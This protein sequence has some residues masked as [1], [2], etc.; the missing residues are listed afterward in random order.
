MK[1]KVTVKAV[2]RIDT[3]EMEQTH[4]DYKST[5]DDYKNMCFNFVKLVMANRRAHFRELKERLGFSGISI[6]RLGQVGFNINI[7]LLCSSLGAFEILYQNYTTGR[8]KKIV[9]SALV[10][11]DHLVKLKAQQLDLSVEMDEG[12]INKY[13]DILIVRGPEEE[14]VLHP[15]DAIDYFQCDDDEENT[16]NN[17]INKGDFLILLIS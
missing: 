8:L 13:R 10:T 12:L 2:Q 16:L 15:V 14:A 11:K 1:V 7:F 9:H 5:K 3:D 4:D 17:D 6:Q